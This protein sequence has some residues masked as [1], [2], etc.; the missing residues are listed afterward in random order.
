MVKVRSFRTS[1]NIW[2]QSKG[3]TN[4][5]ILNLARCTTVISLDVLVKKNWLWLSAGKLK[6]LETCEALTSATI[7]S[8][9]TATLIFIQFCYTQ[10]QREPGKNQTAVF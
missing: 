6:L 4:G 7:L 5:Y 3:N 10:V 2:S 1:K 9:T 8:N